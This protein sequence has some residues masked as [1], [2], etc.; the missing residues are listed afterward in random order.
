MLSNKAFDICSSVFCALMTLPAFAALSGNSQACRLCK[1]IP[2]A[3][4]IWIVI[5]S[6]FSLFFLWSAITESSD[7]KKKSKKPSADEM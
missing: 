5:L 7:H 1:M 2:I 6:G 3:A 4:Y